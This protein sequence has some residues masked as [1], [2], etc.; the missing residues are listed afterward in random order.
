[1]QVWPVD[2]QRLAG[3]L[4]GRC[5]A[6]K[7]EPS[8]E[9]LEFLAARTEGNLLA[10]HQELAKLA[11][12]APGPA[13]TADTVLESVADS[14]RFDVFR[15]SEAVLA[16]DTTRALRVLAGLR[17]EGTEPALVLWAL[18]RSL[19]EVWHARGGGKAPP[20]QRQA[21]ALAQ[22]LRRSAR[23]PFPALAARAARVDRIVKGR[24]AGDAWDELV[25]LAADLS[26]A[27]LWAAS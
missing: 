16:G 26:G 9:A 17:A 21:A 15:L 6:L 25:L 13:V 27:P 10:A 23:M 20:W 1:V 7:L 5:R 4:R 2:A 12:L 22:A 8:D 11:L 14:A 24:I 3:W 19:R 18:T